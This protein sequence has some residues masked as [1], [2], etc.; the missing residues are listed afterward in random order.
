MKNINTLN[1][2]RC[3][4]ICKFWLLTKEEYYEILQ[5]WL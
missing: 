2:S 4:G 3:M 5:Q 1:L